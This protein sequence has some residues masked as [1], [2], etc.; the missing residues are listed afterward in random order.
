MTVKGGK[1]G[2]SCNLVKGE[3]CS[4]QVEELFFQKSTDFS[5]LAIGGNTEHMVYICMVR[6]I[7]FVIASFLRS[8]IVSWK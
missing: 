6:K 3:G 7:L 4:A 2:W 8:E 5:S 1:N